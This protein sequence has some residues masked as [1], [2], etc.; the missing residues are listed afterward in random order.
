VERE[1]ASRGTIASGGEDSS[2][3]MKIFE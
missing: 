1:P 3:A 2:N